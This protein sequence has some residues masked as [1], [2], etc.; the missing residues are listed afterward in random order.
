[1]TQVAIDRIQLIRTRLQSSLTP[2]T[3]SISDESHLHINHIGAKAS[4]GGHFNL[5]IVSSAFTAKSQIER[6]RMIYSA[7]GDAIGKDIHALSI[8][9]KSPSETISQKLPSQQ[10]VS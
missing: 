4:G 7:L 10:E 6:H 1:M 2:T 3:M 8:K 9:A 5:E